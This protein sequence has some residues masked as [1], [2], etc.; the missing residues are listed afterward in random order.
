MM[1]PDVEKFQYFYQTPLGCVT[2]RL[3]MERLQT[4]AGSSKGLR[5]LGIGYTLPYLGHYLK[6]SEYTISFMPASQGVVHWP[7]PEKNLCILGYETMLP[8]QDAVFDQIFMVHSVEYANY[9]EQILREVWR[10]LAPNGRLIIIVPNRQSIWSKLEFTPFGH[11]KPYSK[12]QLTRQLNMS[13]F[14]RV[15]SYNALFMPPTKIRFF[16]KFADFFE[17][18]G[19]LLCPLIGGVIVMDV[20]KEVFRHLTPVKLHK[21]LHSV[22]F[23]KKHTAS[24]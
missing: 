6:G 24:I 8:F 9:L 11:G 20:E 3:I 18:A 13:M 7:H 19:S 22:I 5:L 1:Y 2:Q 15:M 23:P 14:Q 21:R 4:V 16:H 12:K 10:I 17:K